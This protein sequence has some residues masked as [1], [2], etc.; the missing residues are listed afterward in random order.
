MTDYISINIALL[1]NVIFVSTCNIKTWSVSRLFVSIWKTCTNYNILNIGFILNSNA[2]GEHAQ[3]KMSQIVE[4]VHKGGGSNPKSKKSTFQMQTTL[5]RGGGSEFFTFFPNSINQKYNIDF[6]DWDC[7]WHYY[8]LGMWHHFQ[9][10][11]WIE[12][13][14][15]LFFKIKEFT[16]ILVY[17]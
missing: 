3:K 16:N 10:I 15:S 2:L 11:K 12:N 8:N 6:Y 4:K 9:D 14:C 17:P 7:Y 13:F 1:A 5:T